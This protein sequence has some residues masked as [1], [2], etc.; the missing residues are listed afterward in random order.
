[1]SKYMSLPNNYLIGD[2]LN[3]AGYAWNAL[4]SGEVNRYILRVDHQLVSSTRLTF[5]M[6]KESILTTEFASALA[7]HRMVLLQR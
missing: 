7:P 1:M 2:G 4:G 5:N 6:S 3:T